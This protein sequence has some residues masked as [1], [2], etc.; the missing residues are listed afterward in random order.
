MPELREYRLTFGVQYA[1]EPH[2][3]FSAADPKGWVAVMAPDYEA[4]RDLV[5]ERLGTDWAFLRG[6]SE[7]RAD[8]YPAGEIARWTVGDLGLDITNRQMVTSHDGYVLVQLQVRPMTAEEAL[9]HAAWLVVTASTIDPQLPP[10]GE[11]LSAVKN[12]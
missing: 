2:P 5:V 7:L 11:L 10:F 3:R 4:A 12:A 1:H 9:V 6:A 8:R